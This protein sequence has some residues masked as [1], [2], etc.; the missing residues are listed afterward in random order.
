MV[1]STTKTTPYFVELITITYDKKDWFFCTVRQKPRN[2]DEIWA[3]RN[4]GDAPV[5]QMMKR[6]GRANIRV[7]ITPNGNGVTQYEGKRQQSII[8]AGLDTA[9][10]EDRVLNVK[11]ARLKA[12]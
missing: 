3:S 4:D 9:Y 2:E 8:L 6:A 12:A 1:N 10:G 5:Y 11:S 7:H